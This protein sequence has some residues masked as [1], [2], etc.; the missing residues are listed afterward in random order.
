MEALTAWKKL[1]A[2][3][4]QCRDVKL[5]RFKALKLQPAKALRQEGDVNRS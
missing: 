2:A 5:W 3:V 4:I 1:R